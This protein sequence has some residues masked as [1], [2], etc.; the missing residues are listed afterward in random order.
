[1]DNQKLNVFVIVKNMF[2]T[3]FKLLGDLKSLAAAEAQL[4][5]KSFVNVSILYII[6]GLFVASTWLCLLALFGAILMTFGFSAVSS[7]AMVCLLNLVMLVIIGICILQQKK[8]I[9][10][11]ATRKQITAL[12]KFKKD[13]SNEKLITKN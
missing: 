4:T 3:F 11:P 7:I 5:L 8:H 9:G 12:S 2:S 6:G 1:M 10:F 13:A